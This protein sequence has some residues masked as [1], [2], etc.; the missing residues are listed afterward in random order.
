MNTKRTPKPDTPPRLVL[1]TGVSRGLGRAMVEE[2]IRLGH[3]VIG[4]SRSEADIKELRS[5]H[6]VPHR[7]DVVDVGNDMNIDPA[8]IEKACTRRTRAIMPVHLTGRVADMDA[9][10]KIARRR[11]LHNA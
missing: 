5:A 9:I 3:V 11:R 8:L 6:A 4:C 1:I 7:F 2:F 10:L